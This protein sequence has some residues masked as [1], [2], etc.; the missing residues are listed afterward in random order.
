MNNSYMLLC[1]AFN[2][3]YLFCYFVRYICLLFPLTYVQISVCL[4]GSIL[5]LCFCCNNEHEGSQ[6]QGLMIG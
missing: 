1:H 4:C 5:F 3:I 2:K 6:S